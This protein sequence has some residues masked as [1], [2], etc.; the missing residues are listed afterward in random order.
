MTWYHIIQKSRKKERSMPIYE[1]ECN[2]CTFIYERVMKV[3]EEYD[4]LAC[5]QCGVT[6]PKKLVGRTSFHSRERFEERL[7]RRMAARAA[8][9]KQK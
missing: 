5:P 8:D 7:A 3:G 4:N 9:S 6:S 2:A 1:F